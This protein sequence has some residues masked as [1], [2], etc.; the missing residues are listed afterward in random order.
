MN[1][2]NRPADAVIHWEHYLAD[3]LPIAKVVV[4]DFQRDHSLNL[5]Q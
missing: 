1:I 5:S 4:S 3:T 2:F